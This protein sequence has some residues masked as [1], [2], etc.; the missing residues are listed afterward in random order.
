MAAVRFTRKPG[1]PYTAHEVQGKSHFAIVCRCANDIVCAQARFKDARTFLCIISDEKVS[2]GK[3]YEQMFQSPPFF[4]QRI[5]PLENCRSET[6]LF[7]NV[8]LLY[9]ILIEH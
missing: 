8:A 1:E 3:N 4:Q 2:C 9:H 5:A 7:P 6:L